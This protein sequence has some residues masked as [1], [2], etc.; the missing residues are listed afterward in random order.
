MAL[1]GEKFIDVDGVRTRYVDRGTG[2][3]IVL[4][5]GGNFG[6]TGS[7]D[8]TDD[9]GGTIDDI[10]KWGR[11]VAIDKLGQGYTE[12]PKSDDDYTMAAVVKH[13]Y[14]TLRAL[15]IESAHLVGHSRGGYLTCRLTVDYP[16]IAKSCVIVSS[17]TCAPG[18][19]GNEKAFAN[20][21]KP[22]LTAESQRWVLEHYSYSP[23]C[24]T[25]E[26]VEALAAIAQ[27]QSY[28]EAVEKMTQEGYLWTKF[29]PGLLTDKE[30]MF[31]ILQTRGIQRPVL[32][33]WGYNDPTVS[34]AQAY[35]LY[36]ILAEKERRA[37]WQTLNEAGHFCYREQ[38][39][40]FNE[41]LQSFIMNA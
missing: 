18:T 17:N 10:A 4:F 14:Q 34:H 1:D 39:K 37:R 27:Q 5:H 23:D 19:G 33:I 30:E 26:W 31:R 38:R 16:E 41:V 20:Q 22:S 24:V 9:W 36:R 32:Q 11:V 28:A 2:D 40:R 8:A 3:T 6:S 13:A 21:P 25:D 15:S 7:A 12:N 35:D 29:L